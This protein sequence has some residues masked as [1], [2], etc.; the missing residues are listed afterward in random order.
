MSLVTLTVRLSASGGPVDEEETGFLASLEAGWN[1]LLVFGGGLISI[2]GVLLPWLVVLAVIGIPVWFLW[3]RRRSLAPANA[4][5]PGVPA[6]ATFGPPSP[7]AGDASAE[8]VSARA[9][10]EPARPPE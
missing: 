6:M 8:P 1:A 10:N 4:A 5:T 2:F 3:R 9:A 7:A